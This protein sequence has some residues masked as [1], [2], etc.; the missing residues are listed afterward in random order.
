MA[1]RNARTTLLVEREAIDCESAAAAARCA[2]FRASLRANARFALRVPPDAPWPF[3]KEIRAQ[4][5]GVLGLREALEAAADGGADE[6]ADGGAGEAAGGGAGH[7]GA[8]APAPDVDL[9]LDRALARYGAIAAL[10]YSEIMR[11]VVRYEPRPR[12][13]R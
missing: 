6:A 10:P 3:G 8:R 9:L 4:C 12:S 5:G 2:E 11:A 13:R 7:P 1:C